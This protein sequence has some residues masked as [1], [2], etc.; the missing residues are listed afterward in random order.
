MTKPERMDIS[1]R[2][3]AYLDGELEGDQR[4]QVERLLRGNAP[5]RQLL[6][7]L[8]CTTALVAA[9]PRHA[10]PESIA[11]DLE[12]MAARRELL[13]DF[14]DGGLQQT[15]LRTNRLRWLATAA[16]LAF[17]VGGSAWMVGWLGGASSESEPRLALTDAVPDGNVPGSI[18][19]MVAPGSDSF[20]KIRSMPEAEETT[21]L[22]RTAARRSAGRAGGDSGLASAMQMETAADL[23]EQNNE[24]QMLDRTRE[25]LEQID[26]LTEASV[27]P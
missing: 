17:A 9:L 14:D 10:A 25:L 24:S 8:R 15:A 23:A 16:M 11:V 27:T 22:A 20:S 7:E 3:S 1:Q 5:A 2:L 26:E 6:E 4:R 18:P 21:D 12:A 19:G 13:S